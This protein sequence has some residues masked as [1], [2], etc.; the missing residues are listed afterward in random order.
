MVITM[1]TTAISG[2][3]GANNNNA[4]PAALAWPVSIV[5]YEEPQN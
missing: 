2:G 1:I 4:S 5:T 3:G